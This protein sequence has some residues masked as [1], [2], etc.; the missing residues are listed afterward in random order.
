MTSTAYPVVSQLKRSFASSLTQRLAVPNDRSTGATFRIPPGKRSFIVKAVQSYKVPTEM[1]AI[2]AYPM[3]G[4]HGIY[5]YAKNSYHQGQAIHAVKE[6][7]KEEITE[8]LDITMFP[9]SDTFRIVDMGCSAGPNTFFAVQ[10][11]LEAVEKKYQ[12]QGLDHCRLP[13]YQVFFNDHSSNDFNTLFTSLPPNRNY[14]VAGVPGSF[15]VRLFPEASLHIVISSYAIQWISH[16]PKELV[17]KSSP[18]WNKGRTYYAHAGVETIKAYADQFAKDMD[19]FLHFR[20]LEVVPGGMVLLTIPGGRWDGDSDYQ[21]LPNTLHDLLESCIVDMAKKGI[22]SEEKLDSFN[23]PQY[24]P[25]PQEMEA[26]VKRNGSF[27]IERIECLHDE[28]KQA[29]P[30]EARAFSS[31]VRAGLEFLLSEHFG[32]EIM[33]ELF[34]SFTRKIEENEVFDLGVAFKLL[35]VLKRNESLLI[36]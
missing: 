13:E 28:K 6:L 36:N 1:P 34:D 5:S 26:A 3:N 10:N 11:V 23:V 25:S 4:G 12:G 22:I 2:E 31:H 8:K 33:D 21:I 20:A 24:F 9:S 32:H 35:V 15:H 7:I 30:K 29:N 19:N 17:D 27:C 18:A 14:Y 16:I